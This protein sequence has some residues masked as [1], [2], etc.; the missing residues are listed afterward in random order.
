MRREG[1]DEDVGGAGD[2][3]KSKQPYGP[4]TQK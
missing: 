1:M 4:N 2:P 3:H